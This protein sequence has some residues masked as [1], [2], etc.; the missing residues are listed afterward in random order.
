MQKGFRGVGD[1]GN[2]PKVFLE[3]CVVDCRGKLLRDHRL[4]V[5]NQAFLLKVKVGQSPKFLS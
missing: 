5:L 2:P 4:C 1:T 3:A